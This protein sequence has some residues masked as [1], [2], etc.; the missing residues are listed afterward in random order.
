MA[1]LLQ[2]TSS[3]P[4]ANN[5]RHLANA[6]LRIDPH[7]REVR[8]AAALLLIV[9]E[10]EEKPEV[11]VPRVELPAR[12]EIRSSGDASE[13]RADPEEAAGAR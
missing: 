1:I 9:P 2:R 3:E 6:F 11:P 13:E 7:S 5:R 4:D 8:D 10:E 12:E